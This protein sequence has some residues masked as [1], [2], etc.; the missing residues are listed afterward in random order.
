MI[1]QIETLTKDLKRIQILGPKVLKTSFSKSIKYFYTKITALLVSSDTFPGL[2][3][4]LE[5]PV[6]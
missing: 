1:R 5:S 2:I 4:G 6:F 3:L